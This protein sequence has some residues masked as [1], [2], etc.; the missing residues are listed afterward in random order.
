MS[1][2]KR[3]IA[4]LDIKGNKLI[5]GIRFEGLRVVG[6]PIEAANKYANNGADELFY[7]DAVASLYGRNGLTEVLRKTCKKVFIPITAGG[8]IRSVED[9]AKLLSAGADKIALNTAALEKPELIKELVKSFGSQ[10][11]V[12]SI[13]ARKSQKNKS[14]EAMA[15]TGRERTNVDVIEWIK[16]VQELGAGEIFLTSVDKDGTCEGPD[17]ELI[18]EANK[19]VEIPLIVGGGFTLTNSVYE[20]LINKNIS[21]TGIGSALHFEKL[22]IK[23]LKII[24]NERNINIRNN[25]NEI[26]EIIRSSKPLSDQLIGIIDYGM[27]NHQSLINALKILGATVRLTS[28]I[29][30]LRQ[31]DLIT[32]PGVGAFQEGIKR[33]KILRLDKFLKD[34]TSEGK[35]FLG[36][37]LGMQLLFEDSEELGYTKG[38]NMIKGNVVRLSNKDVNEKPI[39]VPHIGWNT[40]EEVNPSSNKKEELDQ[41]FVHSYVASNV[42]E[43]FIK[44]KFI[45][46]GKSYIA[47][48]QDKNISGLQFHPERSGE[49]GLKILAGLINELTNKV[50]VK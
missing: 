48:V 11:I 32:L 26:H 14:W 12:I 43:R 6:D 36:I 47:A 2:K 9:A 27:G 50:K 22:S 29:N 39:T 10:C 30:D 34:I 45:Y 41:Y 44:Y 20:A 25:K 37:C 8:G 15:E 5:K 18:N 13:Q 49:I 35:P 23:E 17:I 3:L 4:R 16:K 19:I 40:L 21:G 31:C 7:I 46:G 42:E 24:L 1:L 28:E 38:L 33:L